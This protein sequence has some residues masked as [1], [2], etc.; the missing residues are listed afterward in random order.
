MLINLMM[1]N[2]LLISPGEIN[3]K[4]KVGEEMCKI[5]LLKS[6][7]KVS[8][9]GYDVWTTDI[10]KKGELSLY[11]TE[12][13]DLGIDIDYKSQITELS[14]EEVLVCVKGDNLGEYYGAL[15][16][17]AEARGGISAGV[18][19]WINLEVVEEVFL[20]QLPSDLVTRP[21]LVWLARAVAA[22]C[23]HVLLVGCMA[24]RPP[25]AGLG[26]DT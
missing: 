15:V 10:S 5:I 4:T 20:G 6:E 8:L 22:A 16:Y 2:A 12:A 14:E 26:G 1:V 7:E 13:F 9:K 21:T 23:R 3:L 18:G 25:S 19:T 24:D 17:N 11:D